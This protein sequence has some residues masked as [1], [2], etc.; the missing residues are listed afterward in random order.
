MRSTM[1]V[2]A[3]EANRKS[4]TGTKTTF[5]KQTCDR[6][7]KWKTETTDPNNLK[8]QEEILGPIQA[9][10]E[11]P[12]PI[13]FDMKGEVNRVC[14]LREASPHIGYVPYKARPIRRIHKEERIN[15]E[16]L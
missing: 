13:K 11:E 7:S 8:T 12:L 16:C 3:C 10:I 2:T 14:G 1:R 6:C 9:R 15:D 5:Q 4:E